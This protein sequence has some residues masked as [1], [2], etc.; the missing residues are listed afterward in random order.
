MRETLEGLEAKAAMPTMVILKMRAEVASLN[1]AAICLPPNK[2]C[3]A[4]VNV[5]PEAMAVA[6][7]VDMVV[8]PVLHRAPVANLT[9]CAPALT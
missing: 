4:Q 5:K 1:H 7:V 8:H 3:E 2:R 9:R 6:M